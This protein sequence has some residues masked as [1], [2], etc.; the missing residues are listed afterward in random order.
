MT[1]QIPIWKVGVCE[2]CRCSSELGKGSTAI[3]VEVRLRMLN[4]SKS[5]TLICSA[6]IDPTDTSGIYIPGCDCGA[7][8]I[9]RMAL[10][11]R[12]ASQTLRVIDCTG[13]DRIPGW[14][15]EGYAES[16]KTSVHA[17]QRQAFVYVTSLGHN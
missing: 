9:A 17:S 10:Q 5:C 8:Q 1:V 14:N 16:T 15:P 7:R 12:A 2:S 4:F 6:C 11:W 3:L 13:V